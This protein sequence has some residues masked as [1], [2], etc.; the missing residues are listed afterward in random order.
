MLDGL[1]T[2]LWLLD[3]NKSSSMRSWH[4]LAVPKILLCTQQDT[5]CLEHLLTEPILTVCLQ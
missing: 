3:R 4:I 2:L 5:D 1:T